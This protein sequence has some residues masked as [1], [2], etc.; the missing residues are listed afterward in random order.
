VVSEVLSS[1]T[2]AP[3]VVDAEPRQLQAFGDAPERK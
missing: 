1:D 2:S 3:T